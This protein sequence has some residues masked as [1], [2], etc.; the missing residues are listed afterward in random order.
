MIHMEGLIEAIGVHNMQI[1]EKILRMGNL[2]KHQVKVN[3]E[4]E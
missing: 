3:E 1:S 4:L 2:V